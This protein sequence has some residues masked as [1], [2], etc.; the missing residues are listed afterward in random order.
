MKVKLLLF[1]CC[2]FAIEGWANS[3][4]VVKVVQESELCKEEKQALV[5]S[6]LVGGNSALLW[7]EA[8]LKVSDEK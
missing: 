3:E 4:G 8:D 6:I 2:L 1:I 7:A 5:G